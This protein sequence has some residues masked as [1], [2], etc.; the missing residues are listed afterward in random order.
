MKSFKLEE[1]SERVRFTCP[2][3]T[4]DCL[5]LARSGIYF[6]VPQK[7]QLLNWGVTELIAKE[8]PFTDE[9]NPRRKSSLKQFTVDHLQPGMVCEFSLLTED[10]KKLVKGGVELSEEQ[11]EQLT[12]WGIE[13]LL[14][15]TC[16]KPAKIRDAGQKKRPAGDDDLEI[17]PPVYRQAAARE[18]VR[19]TYKKCCVDIENILVGLSSRKLL[20]LEPVME[21]TRTLLH[22]V[23]RHRWLVLY[24]T[25]RQQLEE[26]YIYKYSL[27]TAIV[28]LLIGDRMELPKRQL[29]K[30][31]AAALIHDF[32]MLMIPQKLRKKPGKFSAVER[33]TM[34]QHLAKSIDFLKE[35][36]G[37]DQTI[38]RAIVQHHERYDGTG[39]PQGLKDDD[40]GL[41]ARIINL[42]MNYVALNQPR[43]NRAEHG[44]RGTIKRVILQNRKRFDPE[45][46]EVFLEVIGFYPPGTI[47]RLKSG[48]YALVIRPCPN[49]HLNPVIR[50]LTDCQGEDLT[51]PYRLY[52]TNSDQS[53]DR[54]LNSSEHHYDPFEL[55]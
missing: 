39:Y 16:P 17:E 8:E 6:S 38:L 10:K 34:Q 36:E 2:V 29:W 18:F 26:D 30:L 12:L 9:S 24:Y 28:S 53:I 37:I 45:I 27:N 13:K 11:I 52:L 40:I 25:V 19:E 1:L 48:R 7:I 46:L 41:F 54:M 44:E 50:V 33:R 15:R 42:S 35:I 5:K 22:C 49:D 14:S 23:R 4:T 43:Y 47:V 3:Y 31:G 32:G 55:A 21:L 20:E 51:N